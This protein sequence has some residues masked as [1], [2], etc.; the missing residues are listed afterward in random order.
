MNFKILHLKQKKILLSGSRT[1]LG[2]KRLSFPPAPPQLSHHHWLQLE[3]QGV[4]LLG[5]ATEMHPVLFLSKSLIQA[6]W[7]NASEVV[8]GCKT[9][10]NQSKFKI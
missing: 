6:M 9:H 1:G 4:N 10:P 3:E 7:V 2:I 8:L 5:N